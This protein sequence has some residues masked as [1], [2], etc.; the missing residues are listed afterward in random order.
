M[1]GTRSREKSLG[2]ETMDLADL[3]TRNCEK[4]VQACRSTLTSICMIKTKWDPDDH[5]WSWIGINSL[6]SILKCIYGNRPR[7]YRLIMTHLQGRDRYQWQWTDRDRDARR[8]NSS[9]EFERRVHPVH[10]LIAGVYRQLNIIETSTRSNSY[11]YQRTGR[12]AMKCT[13]WPRW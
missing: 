4:L 6:I 1:R 2:K 3:F 7:T 8:T 10:H 13:P 12:Q 9:D 5:S 11:R